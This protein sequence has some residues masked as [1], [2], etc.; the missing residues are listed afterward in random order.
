M[1]TR[2]E[3]AKKQYKQLVGMTKNKQEKFDYFV[4]FKET[5]NVAK[6]V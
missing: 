5:T 2:V 6:L 4:K 3:E 1:Y